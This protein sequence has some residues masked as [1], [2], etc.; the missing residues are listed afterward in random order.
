MEP[1]LKHLKSEPQTDSDLTIYILDSASTGIKIP[2][3][4]WS[5][6]DYLAHGSIRGYN[7]CRF[8]TTYNL[9]TSML[10]MLDS[11]RDLGLFWIKDV[12]QMLY[13]DC[14]APF[15]SIFHW[16][17]RDHNLQMLHAASIGDPTGSV[18]IPGKSGSGK[19]TTALI[20]MLD[21][22]LYQGDDHVL[23]DDTTRPS[24]YSLYNSAKIHSKKLIDFPFLLPMVSNNERLDNEKA[25]FYL[26]D[27]HPDRIAT[28]LPIRLI[29]IPEIT[30]LS[31]TKY[32]PVTPGKALK[33]LAPSTLFQMSGAGL[34]DFQAIANMVRK[35]PCYTIELG[36]NLSEIPKIIVSL[37]SEN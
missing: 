1:A 28:C 14:A 18:L 2:H 3:P 32:Y 24:T 23:I 19:S 30:G 5:H 25:L 35:V 26:Y 36:N 27:Y 9:V 13:T 10:S 31:S 8:H 37:L 17:M 7:N 16:W 33:A 6:E 4:P 22:L 15:R 20:C 34:K 29:L 11:A 12:R 21:G